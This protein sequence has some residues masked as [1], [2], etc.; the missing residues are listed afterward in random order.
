MEN[1]EYYSYA[2]GF[3][4]VADRRVVDALVSVAES[5]ASGLKVAEGITL[6]LDVFYSGVV[7]FPHKLY[8]QAGVLA[9]EME[10]SALFVISA[11][12]VMKAGSIL[13]IDGLR[14]PT[15]WKRTT[16]T[17]KRWPRR[18]RRKRRLLWMRW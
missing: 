7:E 13:A 14:I 18:S 15:C 4:A 17:R 10:N 16:R 6:T 5:N 3:P 1:R 11:L 9:V 12:R 8:Q 2:A